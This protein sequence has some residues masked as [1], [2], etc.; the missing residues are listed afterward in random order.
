MSSGL[1]RKPTD[2]QGCAITA[3]DRNVVVVAGAGTGKT[4][5]LVRRFVTLLEANPDWPISA[6]VAI[7]FTNRAADEMRARV[8]AEFEQRRRDAS[9]D[10]SR[11]RWSELLA[12]IEAAR[13][14]TIHG[15]CS[16]IVRANA[17]IA[18]VD[19]AFEV[20][21][22]TQSAILRSDA[23]N[24]ALAE[25]MQHG[26]LS[27][28]DAALAGDVVARYGEQ[29]IR[30]ALKSAPLL[31]ADIPS[32]RD[33]DALR[34]EWETHALNQFASPN[35]PMLD[36]NPPDNDDLMAIQAREAIANLLRFN[37]GATV[38]DRIKGLRGLTRISLLGGKADLWPDV[39]NAKQ[40]L[41]QARS[42]AKDLL[43]R[44]GDPPGEQ[45]VDA[46][47][48]LAGWRILLER[49][50]V[51]YSRL[52]KLRAALDYDDL[53]RQAAYVLS[54]SEA[55]E[56]YAGSE[57]RHVMV[58]EFQDTNRQQWEI[59][60]RIAPP[61]VRGSLFIVG[62]PKQSIYSFRG[63]DVTVF[64][65]ARHDIEAE[66]GDVLYLTESFRTHKP[67]I[68]S[69]NDL[70]GSILVRPPAAIEQGVY[71][72]FDPSQHLN[73]QRD[74]G[75]SGKYLATYIVPSNKA[76]A[77]KDRLREARVAAQ[78]IKHMV[79]QGDPLVFDPVKHEYRRPRYGDIALLLRSFK[80]RLEYFERAFNDE[81]IPYITLGG[82]GFYGR[83]EVKDLLCALRALHNPADELELA[84]ALHSPLF[85]VSDVD[86]LLLRQPMP[87]EGEDTPRPLPLYRALMT[88]AAE[89]RA[90]SDGYDPLVFSADVLAELA[91]M[92]GRA[93]VEVLLQSLIHA[94]GYM[95]TLAGLP[96]G[97]QMRANV[98]KLIDRARDTGITALNQFV[99]YLNDMTEGEAKEG[100]VA[101]QADDA[102]RLT[103]VHSSKGLEYPVVWIA[104]AC[105]ESR[106]SGNGLLNFSGELGCKMPLPDQQ[107]DP[108]GSKLHP[109]VY[110]RNNMLAAERDD[111]ETR[112]ILYVAATRAQ[113]ALFVSGVPNKEKLPGWL[114][115]IALHVTPEEAYPAP[116]SVREK[117]APAPQAISNA[118]LDFPLA[119]TLPA[120]PP[121]SRFH[122]SASDIKALGGHF[123]GPEDRR[124]TF[125]RRLRQ[126]IFDE[127]TEPIEMLTYSDESLSA[128]GRRFGT[129]VHDALRF[130]YDALLHTDVDHVKSLLE[131]MA[132][133]LG[134][135]KQDDLEIAVDNATRML[136]RYRR[137]ALA[138]EIEQAQAV[139]RELPF[140]YQRD[141]HVIHGYIDLL[142][143]DANGR[144]TVVDYKTDGVK[145]D[146]ESLKRQ[147][148]IYCLQL[149]V[150]SE[151]VAAQTGQTPRAMLVYL[152][153]PDQ[154]VI[155]DSAELQAE[156]EKVPLQ[157][158]IE[159]LS[160]ETG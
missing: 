152:H 48:L 107:D 101:L 99:R 4:F 23:V 65:V 75:P 31:S 134:I 104:D 158:L 89:R 60:K 153:H 38:D 124:Q 9:D 143:R 147:A 52:K 150:Y 18:E 78:Q 3:T 10:V 135:T 149:A 50:R 13:I 111:A 12:Q 45:D 5:V 59:V 79:T 22:E 63:A 136:A 43:E 84:A 100:G 96:D 86:L 122:L 109:Y 82:Q 115:M 7:T 141:G 6:V 130:G 144:W 74:S 92:V 11:R 95:A 56:R 119:R 113:D 81:G 157:T 70:F 64:D 114:G 46:R 145:G 156:L 1:I 26:V 148:R 16:E 106:G 137:S 77:E 88:L 120:A 34:E 27:F 37:R 146:P 57:F 103:T 112:R 160:T 91:P 90:E 53:E 61:D 94:T 121:P 117:P 35:V 51:A 87:V 58:D 17:A 54:R 129:L 93:P 125:T 14:T 36:L 102:V 68:D 138:R 28:D 98:E 154:P 42:D 55:A 29:E 97:Q 83:R 44:I 118:P 123:S 24:I 21:D 40:D 41:K 128:G 30:D 159:L 155:F 19:P 49:T 133:E 62:D 151:A 66:G 140:V 126:R 32:V 2:E 15:L 105:S 85:A 25:V 20:L 131:A 110:R 132:W 76:S 69:L 116:P 73:S 67:L 108:N 47:A 33:V 142:Y 8:R 80:G 72:E 39:K 139:Y 71:I 127:T